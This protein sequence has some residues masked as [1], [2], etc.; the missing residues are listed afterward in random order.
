MGKAFHIL[1][2]QLLYNLLGMNQE[3][4]L[5]FEMEESHLH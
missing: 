1:Y 5:E 2:L 3:V 4:K